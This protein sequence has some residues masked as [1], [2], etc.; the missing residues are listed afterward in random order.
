MN[1]SSGL[2]LLLSDVAVGLSIFIQTLQF[3]A[4]VYKSFNITI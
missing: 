3:S 4:E 1:K 2:L